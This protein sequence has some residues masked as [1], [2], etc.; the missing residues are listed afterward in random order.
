MT[1]SCLRDLFAIVGVIVAL[2]VY[3]TNFLAMKRQRAIDN[4]IRYLTYHQKLDSPDGYCRLN[5]KAMENGTYKRDLADDKME[6]KFNEYLA[7]CE[8]FALLQ[9]AG[10]APASINAYM[11]G[12]FVK[13]IYPELTDREKAQPY[14][15]LAIDFLQ[16][17][18]VEAEKLDSMTMEER[19]AY[20]KKNHFK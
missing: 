8:E 7:T 1:L 14:W 2:A 15:T 12:F 3:I 11:M 17:T 16:K 5:V 20:L 13:H 6:L 9:Q 19:L 10:G 18:K 4:A